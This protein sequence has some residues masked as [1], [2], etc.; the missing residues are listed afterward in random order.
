MREVIR[1][2]RPRLLIFHPASVFGGTE[3]FLTL[4]LPRWN[5]YYYPHLVTTDVFAPFV[6][7]GIEATFISRKIL[8]RRFRPLP[9]YFHL[10]R[11]LKPKRVLVFVIAHQAAVFSLAA[12]LA[13]LSRHTVIRY[14]GFIPKALR[15]GFLFRLLLWANKWARAIIVPSRALGRFVVQELGVPPA[16]L[17][18]IPNPV[19]CAAFPPRRGE[20]DYALWV[21]RIAPEKNLSLLLEAARLLPPVRIKVLGDGPLLDGYCEQAPGNVEFLGFRR[22]VRPHLQEARFLVHTC[23]A[24]G[25][26]YSL[27]EALA[28]G[29]P[30]LS[31]DCPCGPDEILDGGRYGLLFKEDPE[32]LAFLMKELWLSKELRYFFRKR[33]RERARQYDLSR[34]PLELP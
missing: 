12:Y 2:K 16:S 13:G 23:R 18:V 29:L 11:R 10:L 33:A 32:E 24:E 15:R 27:L 17:K 22:D 5:Q 21:G 1:G 30:V 19:D 25:F 6:P 7:S 8:F 34:Y 9:F 14:D 31:Q 26:G 4:L 20:G 28:A 3:R